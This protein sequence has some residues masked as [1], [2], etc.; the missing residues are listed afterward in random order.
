MRYS[1]S[2]YLDLFIINSVSRI[3]FLLSS[4][5]LDHTVTQSQCGHVFYCFH[6]NY[7]LASPDGVLHGHCLCVL[8][9]DYCVWPMSSADTV[10]CWSV[11]LC[12]TTP[13]LQFNSGTAETFHPVCLKIRTNVNGIHSCSHVSVKHMKLH[14]W[15]CLNMTYEFSYSY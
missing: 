10:L 12:E 6:W 5:E 13:Q 1:H 8:S 11:C 7:L 15:K 14:S 9:P 4:K 3:L 2:H